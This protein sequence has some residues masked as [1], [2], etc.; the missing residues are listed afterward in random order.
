MQQKRKL[1]LHLEADDVGLEDFGEVIWDGGVAGARILESGVQTIH[2]PA[3]N[4]HCDALSPRPSLQFNE[5]TCSPLLS[6][7]LC[8]SLVYVRVCSKLLETLSQYGISI[9]AVA[10][11]STSNDESSLPP[12]SKKHQVHSKL[13]NITPC[14]NRSAR[15]IKEFL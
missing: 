8:S 11:D 1:V 5:L 14:G 4:P 12:L 10:G 6:S 15:D 3:H 13:R 7:P 2:I 9:A